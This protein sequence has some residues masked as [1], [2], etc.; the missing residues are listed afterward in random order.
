M[1]ETCKDY[2]VYEESLVAYRYAVGKG[3]ASILRAYADNSK[4]FSFDTKT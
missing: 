2:E 4:Y 3:G 1:D